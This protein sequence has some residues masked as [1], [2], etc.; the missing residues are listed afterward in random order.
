MANS[1]RIENTVFPELGVAGIKMVENYIAWDEQEL[2]E[3]IEK[4]GLPCFMKALNPHDL[5]KSEKGMVQEI[6]TG[7]QAV[8]F[9]LHTKQV[10]GNHYWIAVQ[11]CSRGMELFV[12]IKKDPVFSHTLLFGYGGIYVEVYRDISYGILPL[13]KGELERI[14][15]DSKI[16]KKLLANYR[17]YSI[18]LKQL[19]K[20]V[21]SAYKLVK[22]NGFSEIEFNPVII[23]KDGT[24]VP[25]DIKLIK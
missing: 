25:V 23:E 15:S 2:A 24:V 14:V 8:E 4:V 17:G 11:K 20:L 16:G 6:L 10:H 12:G 18:N 7:K 21:N 9:F 19:G 22:E 3:A 1:K 5:H 13:N